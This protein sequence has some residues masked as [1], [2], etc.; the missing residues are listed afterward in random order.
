MV[1]DFGHITA[2]EQICIVSQYLFHK[3]I[4]DKWTETLWS[5]QLVLEYDAQR[6]NSL[7]PLHKFVE[8]HVLRVDLIPDRGIGIPQILSR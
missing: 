5:S 7:P 8:L 2:S 3:N 6:L 4:I 1:H